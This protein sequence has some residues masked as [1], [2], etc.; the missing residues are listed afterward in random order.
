MNRVL[1]NICFATII[2]LSFVFFMAIIASLLTG[3]P[4]WLFGMGFCILF[5]TPI[6]SFCGWAIVYWKYVKNP[7]LPIKMNLKDTILL[8]IV[9]IM[10]CIFFAYLIL[11]L[12]APYRH[13]SYQ[14]II[15]SKLLLWAFLI[16]WI[17]PS[18]EKT[19]Y[20]MQTKKPKYQTSF[21]THN[22]PLESQIE[23]TEKEESTE[24]IFR[25]CKT[26]GNLLDQD[27]IYCPKCGTK[28]NKP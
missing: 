2:I 22:K 28:I 13:E 4:L 12:F 10:G 26:C 11:L 8:Y 17:S 1:Y 3:D 21:K 19:V 25:Y 14:S 23:A 20:K 27:A 24:S 15:L 5:F 18:V 16:F 7:F 9:H 6:C